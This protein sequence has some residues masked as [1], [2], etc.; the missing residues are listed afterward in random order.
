MR[1][2]MVQAF[3]DLHQSLLADTAGL[4]ATAVLQEAGCQAQP[5]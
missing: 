4:A 2:E 3:T 5:A 1:A